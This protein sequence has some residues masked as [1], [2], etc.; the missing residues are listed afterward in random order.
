[1]AQSE[2]EIVVKAR[3]EA[4]KELKKTEGA[5]E[6]LGSVAG[7]VGKA[8]GAFGLAAT[9]AAI[10]FAS[11]SIKEFSQVGDAVEK[12]SKR[13]G[14]GAEA[15]SALRV[16]AEMGGTSIE[17]IES[18]VKKMELTMTKASDTSV[19]MQKA[20][21]GIGMSINDI[22]AKGTTP[23]I[24]FELLANAIGSVK[25]PAEKTRLAVEAFGKAGTELIPMFEDG[26]FSMAAFREQAAKLGVLFDD[27]SASR[28]AALN[29]ALGKLT[30]AWNGLKLKI[31]GELAPVITG[32]IE[33]QLVPLAQAVLANVPSLEQ[34]KGAFS[35]MRTAFGEAMTEFEKKTGLVS[36]LKNS[37]DRV[38]GTIQSEL[39]PAFEKLLKAMEPLMP[40]LQLLAQVAGVI[41]VVALKLFI[42]V[43]TFVINL[44]VRLIALAAE[45]SAAFLEFIKPTIE[46]VTTILGNLQGAIQFV[47]DKFE[48]LKN[49]A[50]SAFNAIKNVPGIGALGAMI[51]PVGA[52]AMSVA[53]RAA[54]GPVSAGTPYIVGENGPELFI[55]A[56][57]GTIA[58]NGAGD[59]S[60][61]TNMVINIGSFWGGD[62]ER[63]ARDI[64]DLIIRRLQLN[65]RV[66]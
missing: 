53:G 18:A 27:L 8:M 59:G 25:D 43:L 9:A 50:I 57:S 64:G 54:G 37:I 22:F 46:L 51:S 45:V 65:A 19:G 62:P 44:F 56:G 36:Q 26:N 47:I 17:T 31:G 49:S 23:E 61:G 10:G 34:V 41:L 21:K 20:F 15:V 33:K 6:R 39:V 1:M 58:A 12:M 66:S 16:A 5:L 7:T 24:Q 13:T 4:S 11:V 52:A 30:I 48:A 55:P 32:F 3:D 60:M 2:L 63:A 42:E 28:A 14:L 29:D 38:W 40:I 35:T